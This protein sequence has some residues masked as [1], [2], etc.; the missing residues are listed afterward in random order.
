MILCS[1]ISSMDKLRLVLLLANLVECSVVSGLKNTRLPTT[2]IS[3]E[4]GASPVKVVVSEPSLIS[5][6]RRVVTGVA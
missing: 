5:E 2:E 6:P 1:L 4:F 3:E